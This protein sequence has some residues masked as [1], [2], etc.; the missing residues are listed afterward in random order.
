MG[1]T[2]VR[3]RRNTQITFEELKIATGN[4]RRESGDLLGTMWIFYKDHPEY[5]QVVVV[6]Q[7]DV[8]E[9]G[10]YRIE[11]TDVG[12]DGSVYY[13]EVRISRTSRNAP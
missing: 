13:V 6:R 10:D 4:Y 1:D 2:T 12:Q 7:G 5:D 11:V 9:V 3:I 8:I